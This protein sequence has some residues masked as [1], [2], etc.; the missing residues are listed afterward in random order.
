[1]YEDD[2]LSKTFVFFKTFRNKPLVYFKVNYDSAI[3]F[4]IKYSIALVRSNHVICFSGQQLN[5]TGKKLIFQRA[6][7][8]TLTRWQPRLGVNTNS[9][10]AQWG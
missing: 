7:H 8:D 5:T 9:G 4:T 2:I 6:A 10:T 3:N 1:M